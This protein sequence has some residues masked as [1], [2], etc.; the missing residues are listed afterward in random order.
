MEFPLTVP[1]FEGR[2]LVVKTAGFFSGAKLMV[3]GEPA[4]KGKKAGQFV[5]RRN[6]GTQVVA[7]LRGNVIDPAPVVT[8]DGTAVKVAEPF[9]WYEWLWAGL[10]IVLVFIGGL[11]G[12]LCGGVAVY[13]NGQV[14][15]SDFNGTVKFLIMGGVSVLAVMVYLVLAVTLRAAIGGG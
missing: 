1:G 5:L 14:L 7:T 9:K 2:N 3:D 6:D 13:V 11:L 8:I 12:G 15:R 10:P 4:E